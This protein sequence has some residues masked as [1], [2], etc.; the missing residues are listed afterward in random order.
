MKKYNALIRRSGESGA[1]E[2]THALHHFVV[3]FFLSPVH[4]NYIE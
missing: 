1:Q 4:R 3:I 2:A